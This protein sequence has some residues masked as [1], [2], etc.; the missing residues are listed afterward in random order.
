M[1]Q[2]S[3]LRWSLFALGILIFALIAVGIFLLQPRRHPS[4]PAA[5]SHT[6]EINILL[7]GTDARALNPTQDKGGT[8]RIPRE[9]TAHSDNIIIC[10]INLAKTRVNLIAIPRDLLVIVPGLTRAD[11]KTDFTRMEKITHTYFIGGEPLLRRTVE[12]LLGIKIHRFLELNF[13][14]FRM[15]FRL[16]RPF[17]GPVSIGGIQLKDPNQALKFVRQRN[18]LPYDDLDRCRNSLHLIKTLGVR[19]WSLADTRFADILLDRLFAI[20]GT[21]TDLTPTEAK[22]LISQLRSQ[23]FKPDQIQLAVLVSAG[24]AVTLDRYMTTLSCYLPIYPEMEKQIEHY[25]Y[26]RDNIPALDF[27]TQEHYNWPEYM[28]KDYDILPNPHADSLLRPKLLKKILQPPTI[29]ESI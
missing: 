26:D 14:T 3:T 20:I 12:N 11:S 4:V 6:E 25:L 19:L 22:Q 15:V 8:S 5:F 10:H 21:D 17:L 18:G 28:N 13:D 27:M 24:R 29:K 23:G 7:I 16:L 2:S 9:N 1:A